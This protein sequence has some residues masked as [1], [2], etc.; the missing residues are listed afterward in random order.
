MS[1][2]RLTYDDWKEIEAIICIIPGWDEEMT[3]Y[4]YIYE[5]LT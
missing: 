1:E 3:S 2:L 5:Q 4:I